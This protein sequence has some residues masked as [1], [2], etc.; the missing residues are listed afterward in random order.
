MHAAIARYG[1]GGGACAME[2]VSGAHRALGAV[3]RQSS[4][5]KASTGIATFKFFS[6]HLRTASFSSTNDNT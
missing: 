3:G 2:A 1:H 4:H 6:T 5:S